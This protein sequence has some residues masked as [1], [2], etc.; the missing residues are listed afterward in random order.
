[1]DF[2]G[3]RIL[4][5]EDNELNREIGTEILRQYGFE[6]EVAEDGCEAVEKIQN[7]QPGQYHLVLMDVQ[8]PIMDG[9]TATREIRELDSIYASVPIIAMTAN[10]FEED[11]RE[12][13]ECGMDG[14]IS[15]PVDIS[16]LLRVLADILK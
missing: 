15:K 13:L 7:A 3:R 1:M 14:H 16:V 10:A 5:V 8:M 11:K 2:S 4:L 12:A 6:V 9:Y